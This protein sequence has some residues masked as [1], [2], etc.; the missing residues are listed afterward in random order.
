[1]APK[2]WHRPA[3]VTDLSYAM[4][5]TMVF[6]S[7]VVFIVQALA[8][9]GQKEL[10]EQAVHNARISLA[11]ANGIRCILTLEPDPDREY[12]ETQKLI[13]ACFK[14]FDSLAGAEE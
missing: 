11:S 10:L 5:L 14:E 1:M 12:V 7:V 13:D 8:G 6:M 3:T 4:I 9:F 2:E